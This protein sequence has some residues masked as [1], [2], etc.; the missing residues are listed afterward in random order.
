MIDLIKQ[1]NFVA[2]VVFMFTMISVTGIMKIIAKKIKR[3]ITRTWV[4]RSIAMAVGVLCYS[5][6]NEFYPDLV[7]K[8]GAFQLAFA[9]L[10]VLGGYP[11]LKKVRN[12]VLGLVKK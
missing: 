9:I 4:K 11:H 10:L 7:N 1:I 5:L 6:L 3:K 2:V 12:Y 8:N